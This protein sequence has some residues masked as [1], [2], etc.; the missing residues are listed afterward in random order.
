MATA[1][2]SPSVLH[3]MSQLM[4]NPVPPPPTGVLEDAL[5]RAHHHV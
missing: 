5:G 2:A 1:S 4:T 3:S